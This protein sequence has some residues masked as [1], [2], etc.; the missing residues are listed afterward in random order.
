MTG[1]FRKGAFLCYSLLADGKVFV[2]HSWPHIEDKQ[3]PPPN[4]M[5]A[6]LDPNE[7][8]EGLIYDHAVTFLTNI[9]AAETE[10]REP[11]GFGNWKPVSKRAPTAE[12][13]AD[14][15]PII[16]QLGKRVSEVFGDND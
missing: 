3:K 14:Q 2:W 1:L 12:P 5:V 4:R 10:A 8:T 6:T 11:F 9:N 7:I 16:P 13:N 15:D